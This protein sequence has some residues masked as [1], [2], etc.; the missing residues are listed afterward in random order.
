MNNILNT[1]NYK[2]QKQIQKKKKI[3]Y[4]QIKQNTYYNI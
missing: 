1:Y 3:K 4:K 2:M